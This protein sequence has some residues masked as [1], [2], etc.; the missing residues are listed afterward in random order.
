[1]VGGVGAAKKIPLSLEKDLRLEGPPFTGVSGPF[2]PEIPKKS[3][4]ESFW[5]SAKESPENTR[6]SRKIPEKV[7]IWYFS[8]IF[9]LFRVFSGTFLQTPKKTLFETFL[10]FRARRARRLL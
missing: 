6:K 5:G 4:K 10:G 3:R 9:R 2:G 8:G 7:Q 1:M